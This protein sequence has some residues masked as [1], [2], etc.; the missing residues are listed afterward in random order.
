MLQVEVEN[1]SRLERRPFLHPLVLL[2]HPLLVKYFNGKKLY[3]SS[4]QCDGVKS[5]FFS[6][7]EDY[8][9]SPF[10]NAPAQR[11]FRTMNE[12]ALLK[13]KYSQVILL[14]H[15]LNSS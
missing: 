7:Q 15:F 13:L 12:V 10:I 1:C 5:L 8:H 14:D 11:S 4:Q 3:K 6:P 9:T 2:Q